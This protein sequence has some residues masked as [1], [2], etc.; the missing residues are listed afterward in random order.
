MLTTEQTEA[1]EVFVAYFTIDEPYKDM[2]KIDYLLLHE[3][4]HRL[5]PKVFIKPKA[6]YLWHLS[7]YSSEIDTPRTE[8]G[9][10]SCTTSRGIERV[11]SNLDIRQNDC[12]FK[13]EPP[14][15]VVSASK[16]L[17]VAQANG[18]EVF[19]DIIDRVKSERE[20]V[21]LLEGLK[22]QLVGR[23]CQDKQRFVNCCV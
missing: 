9:V 1:L 12:K 22:Y 14:A 20:Y 2:R 19:G 3:Y 18:V 7:K 17:K 10:I 8:S 16:L 5:P 11:I 4:F 21:V 6:K 13:I 23:F 15:R